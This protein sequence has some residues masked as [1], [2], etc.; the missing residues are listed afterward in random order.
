MHTLKE[1]ILVK[2]AAKFINDFD[3]RRL[4][5]NSTDELRKVNVR[6]ILSAFG[7]PLTLKEEIIALIKPMELEV[8]NWK[9]DHKGIFTTMQELSLQFRFHADGTVDRIKTAD[10]FICSKG[11][12]DETRFVLACQY[13][14]YDD[15]FTFFA[16]MPNTLRNN[17]LCKYSTENEN[18]NEHEKNVLKCIFHLLV[19]LTPRF[20]P[21]DTF[22]YASLQSR[23]LNDLSEEGRNSLLRKVFEDSYKIHIGS[24]CLSRMSADHREQLLARFPVKVLRIYLHRP[25]QHFFMDAANKVLGQLSG[26]HFTC[27]LNIIIHQK[28]LDLWADFDYVDLLR[29]FWCRSPDHL[30]QYVQ[31]QSVF[32]NLIAILKPGFHIYAPRF[33][34]S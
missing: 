9:A 3:I 22:T 1:I 27:L 4:L 18:L 23:R 10:S 14:S 33:S 6:R 5:H 2:Y 29:Q 30:K 24:F 26:K 21:W 13:W 34:F 20:E 28:I 17:I 19:G 7:I 25:N 31:G 32:K 15:V 8:K 11:L 16:E 12:D